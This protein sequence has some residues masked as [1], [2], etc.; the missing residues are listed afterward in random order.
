MKRRY[1][2]I[3][4]LSPLAA[5]SFW[6]YTKKTEPPEAPFARVRRETLVSN[7]MTNGRVEPLHFA[8]VRVNMAGS[9]AELP[10]KEGQNIAKGA[11][12]ARLRVPDLDTQ[13]AAARSRLEQA[14]AALANI[15]RGGRKADLVDIDGMIERAKLDRDADLRDFEALSRLE[16]KQ[17]ATREQVDNA[18]RKLQQEKL[19]IDALERKRSALITSSDK[20]VADA[21]LREAESDVRLAQRRIADTIV[22]AP[23]AGTV[24]DLPVRLGAYLNPGDLVASVGM[25]DRLRVRVY[26]D[27]PELGRVA[28]G[29]PVNIG[30]DAMPGRNWPGVV[31]QLPTE[32]HPLGTRQVGEV[33]CTIANPHHAL[34]PG[35]N[36]N[37]EVRSRVVDNALTIPKEALRRDTKGTGVFVLRGDTIHWRAIT[38]GTSSIS[39]VQ[40]ADGLAEGDAVV[41]P[42]DFNLHDGEKIRAVYP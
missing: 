20:A 7:L 21:R 10:V 28:V 12:I 35:T 9:I 41:L 19:N 39:R 34:V 6:A 11:E 26:V 33:Q 13:L 15:E 1:I 36:V 42:T 38:A 29:M 22:R 37:V 16:K 30:W 2:V 18:H 5:L 25:L 4:A 27:E 32:I 17:A 8:S 14:N 31:E 40:V 24:Y 3:L 23:I